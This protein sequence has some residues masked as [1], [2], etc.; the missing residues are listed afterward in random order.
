MNPPHTYLLYGFN[1]KS[2]IEMPAVRG[3]DGD[4]GEL[5]FRLMPPT[6]EQPTTIG[7]NWL[8]ESAANQTSVTIRDVGT[9]RIR[10]G[11]EVYI[12]PLPGVENTRLRIYLMASVLGLLL[13]QRGLLVLHASAIQVGSEA[14]LF[15]GESGFGKST[16]A[17]A[18]SV[19]GYPV[20]ADDLAP[21]Q[22]IGND[23]CIAPGFPRLKLYPEIA[24]SL[25]MDTA[26][27]QVLDNSETKKAH[28]VDDAFAAGVLPVRWIFVL[29]KSLQQN[30][31]RPVFQEA[32]MQL[33]RHSYPTRLGVNG[34]VK[35]FARCGDAAKRTTIFRLK[36]FSTLAEIRHITETIEKQFSPSSEHEVARIGLWSQG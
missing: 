22:I 32:V 14:A 27:M 25:G 1:V 5:F 28:S 4:A 9:Y 30:I 36:T 13:D 21:I 26:K 16:I 12:E 33:V 34:G 3:N 19:N 23:A 35:H 7:S 2:D 6:T 11:S 10:N 31:A 18:M 20:I 29:S 17:A 8:I 24:S 15:L